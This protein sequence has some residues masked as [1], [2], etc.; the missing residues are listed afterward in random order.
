MTTIYEQHDKAFGNVTAA[1]VL[2]DGER[3][4]TVAIKHGAAVT[5]YVRWL[6]EEMTRGRAGGGGYDRASAA[7]EQAAGKIAARKLDADL[8]AFKGALAKDSGHRWDRRLEDA[9]FTVFFAIG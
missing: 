6:G 1:V 3:V 9:G 4:A 7:I 2:K 5:A 8:I